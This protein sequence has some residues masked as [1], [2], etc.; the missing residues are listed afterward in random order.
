MSPP[1]SGTLW[2]ELPRSEYNNGPFVIDGHV[3]PPG[4]QVGVSAYALHHNE[5]Y[6]PEPFQFRPE[7]WFEKDRVH[8]DKMHD[9]FCPFSTGYR[10]CAG[11]AMAYL[12]AEL[13]M[14]KTL[15]YF[16][17]EKALGKE[18]ET[19]AGAPGMGS[20]RERRGEFQLYDIVSSTHS[21]PTLL[22]QTR[23]EY[24]RELEGKH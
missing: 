20:G 18:G 15:W 4:T 3:I 7:R 17:F 6:F 2:R 11:K 24:W 10:G 1:V 9:A 14:A 13:V 5:D 12:E 23:D 19:G 16:D 22:F 8:L 21:G